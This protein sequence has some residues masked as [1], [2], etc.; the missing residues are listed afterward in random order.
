MTWIQKRKGWIPPRPHVEV[1]E[2]PPVGDPLDQLLPEEL[3]DK[4][5]FNAWEVATIC[6]CHTRTVQRWIQEELLLV[7][8]LPG[9]K[10]RITK[11]ALREFLRKYNDITTQKGGSGG[12]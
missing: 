12:G 9:T 10:V 6:G 3:K 2:P 11:E 8:R 7:I 1:V 5:S 4:R